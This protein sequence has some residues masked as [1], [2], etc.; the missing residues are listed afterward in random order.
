VI[1]FVT[2]AWRRF[3]LTEVCLEQRRRVID[4]LARHGVEARCVV[5]ADDDNL[6]I[7]RR[8]DFE[9]VERDN[10]WLGRK[11]NDGIE[12]S[13]R[14]GAEWIVPIGSD[15]WVDPAYFLPLPSPE[16]ARTS[17]IYAVVTADHLLT[18][19][20]AGKGAGPYMLHRSLFSGSARPTDEQ[21]RRGIDRS[22]I[23]SI[24]EVTWDHRDVHELQYVGFRAR[25]Q[26][27]AYWKLARVPGA[28]EEGDPWDRLM[29]V[30]PSDLVE[31]AQPL[32][33]PEP[34]L[35]GRALDQLTA[36]WARLRP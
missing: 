30:Y 6:D 25:P 29:T 33:P 31:R 10:R 3:E 12:F 8:L 4:H 5:I 26:I 1:Y 22:M 34:G 14:Q 36:A 32:V 13:Y 15:S 27:T 21:I 18:M 24:G 20:I 23:R 9:T 17:G 2:P 35:V 7:A 28:M 11:F 16:V 19:R